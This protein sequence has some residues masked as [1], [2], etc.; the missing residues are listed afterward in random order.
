[1][2]DTLKVTVFTEMFNDFDNNLL[3]V[4]NSGSA[5]IIK[6]ITPLMS[7]GFSIYVMLVMLSYWRGH[8]HEPVPDFLQR[9]AGW[10]VVL[11]LGMNIG[12]YS[13]YVVPFFNGLGD[14]IA[15][16][17]SG[18]ASTGAALDTLASTYAQAMWQLLKAADGIEDTLN[19]IAY[20][21]VTLLFGM[22]FMSIAA[23]YI[24]L[25]RFALGLLLALGPMFIS[26]ALFP[27][28]RR[29]CE[30]WIGQCLSYGFLVALMSAAGL[31][32]IRFAQSIAPNMATLGSLIKI[33]LM[34][35]SFV[36]ISLNLPGLASQLSGGVGISSMVGK[37][38]QAARIL[39]AMSN[40]R[41]GTGGGERGRSGGSISQ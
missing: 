41:N 8:N 9:M 17:L 33:V 38:S 14:D 4:I 40:A 10:A 24:I 35:V 13:R 23:A 32:E 29:F 25:A 19:A 18:S 7:A 1:M 30:A 20:I 34:G 22:P 12:Y 26:A 27:A 5:N 6:L 15:Q 3:N 36:V 37:V 11:T 16:A 39:S 21:L 2:A 31:I 28:T